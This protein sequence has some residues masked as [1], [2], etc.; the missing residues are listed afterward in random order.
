[1]MSSSSQSSTVLEF[2]LVLNGDHEPSAKLEAPALHSPPAANNEAIFIGNELKRHL[3]MKI[4]CLFRN[5]TFGKKHT[6]AY[7][8]PR[9]YLFQTAWVRSTLLLPRAPHHFIPVPADQ[10][11][12]VLF[13][14][15]RVNWYV[16]CFGIFA[17][18][19]HL[20]LPRKSP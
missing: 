4:L 9:L 17:K 12:Q 16:I 15:A 7:Q 6:K 5:I 2:L 18:S 20:Q 3:H 10:A 14:C 19:L 13:L 8:A 11:C 1:M